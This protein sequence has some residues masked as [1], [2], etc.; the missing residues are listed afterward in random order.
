MLKN[1]RSEVWVVVGMLATSEKD[2]ICPN[3]P[4]LGEVPIMTWHLEHSVFAINAPLL[5]SWAMAIEV[6]LMSARKIAA[7]CAGDA[8]VS[9]RLNLVM[10]TTI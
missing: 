9:P 5:R 8:L 4:S 10:A 1:S 2:G 6:L 7:N 3:R